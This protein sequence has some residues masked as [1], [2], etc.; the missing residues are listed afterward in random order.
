MERRFRANTPAVAFEVI[1]GEAV[2]MN[3][4][5][6]VYFSA[7]GTGGLVWTWIEQGIPEATIV[8]SLL[9]AHQAVPEVVADAVARFI[10]Q[11]EE[12][13]LVRPLPPAAPSWATAPEPQPPG[14][15]EFVAPV[16]EIYKD[17]QDLLLLDPIHD[18]DEDAGWPNTKPSDE[19]LEWPSP[20]PRD[21]SGA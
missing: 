21:G 19:E 4:K 10:A 20:R 17:M 9:A 8:A 7:Q 5:S 11:L 13:D 16:L 14:N 12:H 15:T 3:L 1:D 18:V 6:G 2:I